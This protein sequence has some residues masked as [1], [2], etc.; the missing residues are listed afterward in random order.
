[1]DDKAFLDGIKKFFHYYKHLAEKSLSQTTEADFFRNLD[2]QSNSIAVIVKHLSGNVRSRWTDFLDSDGE[3]HLR[4]RESEF[5]I[6]NET[7]ED[8]MK[9][10]E[11]AWT[12]LDNTLGQL[13]P[14]DLAKTVYIR[15]QVHTVPDAIIRQ[16]GHLAY[17]TGQIAYLARHF[18]GSK[19][20][21]LS[22]PRGQSE[23]F[24][25]RL[26]ERGPRGGHFTD[27]IIT[28]Q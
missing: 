5:A 12:I 2:D 4:N 18:A 1:M 27:D 9:Q 20:T 10:W 11:D 16:L 17:H 14:A 26:F 22:I 24:N 25:K 19:W 8:I 13:R 28:K 23:S 3:K 15:N 7:R 21:T 6:D